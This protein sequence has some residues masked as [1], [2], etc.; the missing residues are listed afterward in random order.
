VGS[1][2]ATLLADAGARAATAYHRLVLL[3]GPAG[4][5]KTRLLREL[6]SEQGWPLV[7]VGVAL[8][9]RLLELTRR[10]RTLQ[11]PR[12]LVDLVGST[13]AEP[14]LL[15]NP[16]LLFAV[17]LAQDPLR[18]LQS[19]SRNRTLVVAW[20]GMWHGRYL[21]YGEPGHPEA[22]RYQDPDALVLPLEQQR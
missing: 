9:E 5:G 4:F 21:S 20:P 2:T 8:S 16:E 17:E 14:V 3:V 1:P 11:A 19:A 15:D 12:L 18:L 10:Q 22:R 6:A 13:S 7:N